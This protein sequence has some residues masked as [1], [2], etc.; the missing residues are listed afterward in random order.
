MNTQALMWGLQEKRVEKQKV[1]EQSAARVIMPVAENT[2][3]KK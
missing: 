2:E 3:A 1:K